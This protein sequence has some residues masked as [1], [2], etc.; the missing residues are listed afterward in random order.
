MPLLPR[1]RHA[2]GL[3]FTPVDYAA[4]RQAGARAYLLNFAADRDEPGQ[5]PASRYLDVGERLGLAERYKC[6]I[7]SPWYRVPVVPTGS[8]MLSKR[9]HRYPRV[10]LNCVDA[11]TTDTIYRGRMLPAAPGGTQRRAPDLVAAFH[12]S[13]TLLT[14]EIEGRSFGGG[15]LELVPSEVGRL[16]VAV[17]ESFRDE[18]DRLDSIARSAS[19]AGIEPVV[20]ETDRLL[21]K[22]VP[23]LGTSSLERL[24][25]ARLMLLKRR[26]DRGAG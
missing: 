2:P 26:L 4:L 19:S 23:G 9:S 7:R 11:Y 14:A 3:R 5:L 25:E 10:I 22:H 18:L 16:L 20:D 17:P 6:R 8:L 24:R 1:V 12:N 15:V 21:T 13:L